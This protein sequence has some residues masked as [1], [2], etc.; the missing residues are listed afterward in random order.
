MTR[1]DQS[2]IGLPARYIGI[3]RAP[4]TALP[5][6]L[7]PVV[8]VSLF[9]V[10]CGNSSPK[11]PMAPG[12]AGPSAEPPAATGA[13]ISCLVSSGS[14]SAST[15]ITMGASGMTGVSVSVS[16][17]SVSATTDSTGH[18]KLSGVPAGQVRL[19]FS[20]GGANGDVDLEDVG[21]HENIMLKV[22]TSGSGM[23]I[24]LEE[25]G[26]G[27]ESQLEGLIASLNAGAHSFVVNDVTVTVPGSAPIAHGSRDMTFSDLVV[28]ARVHVKGSMS[29]STLTATRIEVQQSG[30]SGPGNGNGGNDNDDNDNN[31]NND[32]DNDD[33]DDNP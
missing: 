28:G 18:F 27:H 22:R 16:G 1:S 24:E 10:A 15:T 11:S 26:N 20:G 29:G 23:E 19:Q 30:G 2:L 6:R 32:N 21:E 7:M 33:G 14:A 31:D 8:I 5:R 3:G 13:T 17:T 25:R 12:A 9:A 4:M